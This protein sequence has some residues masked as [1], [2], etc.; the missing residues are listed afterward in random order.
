MTESES[1]SENSELA[2][3]GPKGKGDYIVKEG[4]SIESIAFEKGLLPQKIWDLHDNEELKKARKDQN[5]LLK[6][7]KL[8]IP[9]LQIKQETRPT[10][11]SHKF[12]RKAVP[13]MF[14]L[15]LFINGSPRANEEYTLSIAGKETK[16]ETDDKGVLESF[17]KPNVQSAEL[18]IGNDIYELKFGELN[19]ITE[20]SGFQQRLNNLGFNCGPNDGEFGLKTKKGMN[21]FQSMFDLPVTEEINDETINKLETIH[22]KK[23]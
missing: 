12:R 19:P 9:D 20:I 8:T 6:G 7:D 22:D 11:K 13:S 17:V 21:E 15:Q 16:K 18:K 5:I 2:S 23:R 3:I 4:D 10:G 14:R 1:A